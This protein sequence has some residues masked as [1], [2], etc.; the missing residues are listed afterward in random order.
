M[1]KGAFMEEQ[2]SFRS[3]RGGGGWGGLYP[4]AP[5]VPLTPSF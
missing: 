1:A 2:I 4:C 3:E 5:K